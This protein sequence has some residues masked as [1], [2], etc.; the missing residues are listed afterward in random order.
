VTVPTKISA[1]SRSPCTISHNKGDQ[2]IAIT[3]PSF[4]AHHRLYVC[5]VCGNAKLGLLLN[6][7]LPFHG[8]P[9]KRC[10]GSKGPPLWVGQYTEDRHKPCTVCGGPARGLDDLAGNRY[11]HHHFKAV[12]KKALSDANRTRALR[13]CPFCDSRD[14]QVVEA[15]SV[16]YVICKSCGATGPHCATRVESCDKWDRLSE[17]SAS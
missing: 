14:S 5:P 13:A 6:K 17:V 16:A 9:N 12:V 3:E 4:E 8:P 2:V 11:C 10:S 1:N 15:V 7:T